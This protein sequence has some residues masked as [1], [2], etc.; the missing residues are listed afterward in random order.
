MESRAIL[1]PVLAAALLLGGCAELL[2]KSENQLA[3]N[4]GSFEEAR[5]AIKRI[6]HG[7]TTG[8]MLRRDGI[9]PFKTPNVQLLTYSDITLRFPV[10]I[11]RERLDPGLRQC[12]EAGKACTGY[13]ITARDVK[14]DRTGNF[15]LD[16]LGFERKAEITGWTF[17][18]LVLLV[19]DR[20]VYTLYGGQPVMHEQEVSRQPLGPLQS[21]G[22][23]LP[24][25]S[26]VK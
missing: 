16:A 19:D 22:D 15:W 26:L 5:A 24:L 4:W 10:N 18:A 6:D 3:S 9:D 21:F 20:V 25:S 7:K 12:L 8:E 1:V 11:G 2:P 23:S 14:R 17:N 13:A